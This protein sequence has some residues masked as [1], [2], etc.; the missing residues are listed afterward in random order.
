MQLVLNPSLIRKAQKEIQ[1]I[2]KEVDSKEGPHRDGLLSYKELRRNHKYLTNDL[3]QIIPDEDVP[4]SQESANKN[5]SD[6]EMKAQQAIKNFRSRDE[7]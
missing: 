3:I 7:L 1:V 2:F 5:L 4:M 6:M